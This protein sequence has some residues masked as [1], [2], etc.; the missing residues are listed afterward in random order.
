MFEITD[1][2]LQL[3]LPGANGL[4]RLNVSSREFYSYTDGIYLLT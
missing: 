4:I 3:H 2:W 1:L